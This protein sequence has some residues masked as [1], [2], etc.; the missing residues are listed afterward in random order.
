MVT[1]IL[2]ATTP[3][4]LRRT[5]VPPPWTA[6]EARAPLALNEA[7]LVAQHGN[8]LASRVRGDGQRAAGDLLRQVDVCLGDGVL[9]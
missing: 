2:A 6:A 4:P 7:K 9:G 3:L 8:D 5:P 1:F